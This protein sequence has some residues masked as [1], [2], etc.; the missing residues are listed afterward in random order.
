MQRHGAT[1]RRSLSSSNFAG[2]LYAEP[3]Q[4]LH[5]AIGFCLGIDPE[6]GLGA[7]TAQHQ[8]GGILGEIFYAVIR[9]YF[10]ERGAEQFRG[11]MLLEKIHEGSAFFERE[12][13]IDTAIAMR[14][15]LFFE[16]AN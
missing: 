4:L 8:P 13:S 16:P 3:K 11:G 6:D 12:M 14:P 2:K 10:G 15:E 7:R 1:E 9:F 5:V